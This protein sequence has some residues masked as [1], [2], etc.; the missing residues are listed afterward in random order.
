MKGENS[1]ELLNIQV[2]VERKRAL[3]LFKNLFEK[4]SLIPIL[5]AG[6]S[7]GNQTDNNGTIPSVWDLHQKLFSIISHFSG[8]DEDDL[9]DIE[10][11][12]LSDLAGHFWDIYDRV[13]TNIIDD[14]FEYVHKNFLNISYRKGFQDVFLK[15][16]WPYLFTLNYD[17]LIENSDRKYYPI[18]P[19]DNIN[20]HV[21][22]NKIKL[23]K[24]YGDANKYWGTG[25]RK[26]FILSRD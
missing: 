1:M 24:L 23:F 9:K 22:R 8:Y 18:I 19:Y 11:E 14:Y 5:G 10:K 21:L 7:A 2:A 25:D 13:P 15:I 26:Y 12:N 16:R 4:D 20:T 17:S 3:E 6:F